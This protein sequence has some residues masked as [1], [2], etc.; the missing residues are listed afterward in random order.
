MWL[1]KLNI[2]PDRI[3]P[4]R[5]DQNGRHERMHRT[6]NQEAATPRCATLAAQQLRLDAWRLDF[7][8]QRP[9]EALGQRCPAAVYEP[10]RRAY[11]E[12]PAGWDYPCDHH[13]RRVSRDGYIEWQD[14]R[15]YL[16]EALGG[17]H[18]AISRRD[19]GQWQVSFQAFDWPCSMPKAEP[20]AVPGWLDRASPERRSNTVTQAAG[21]NCYQGSRL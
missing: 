14:Q 15:I 7:N 1:L 2:W 12:A 21:L 4:G 3:A 8:T 13:P 20:C 19:D 5:P 10:S 17:E 6:L 11:R 16:S 9:H 18:V